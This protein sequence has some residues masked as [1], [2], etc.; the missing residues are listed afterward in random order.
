ML[1]KHCRCQQH[2]CS[3]SAVDTPPQQHSPHLNEQERETKAPRK[4]GAPTLSF[5][6]AASTC[7]PGQGFRKRPAADCKSHSALQCVS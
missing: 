4:A 5:W 2:S 6:R 1:F 3:A 7:T